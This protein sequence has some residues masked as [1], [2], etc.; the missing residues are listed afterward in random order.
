MNK[1]IVYYDEGVNRLSISLLDG[2]EISIGVGNSERMVSTLLDK[3][4]VRDL[5]VT[6]TNIYIQSKDK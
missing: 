1:E 5:I 3:D 6:L 4:S 2:G